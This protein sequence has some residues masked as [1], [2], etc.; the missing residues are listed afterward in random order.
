MVVFEF[1]GTSTGAEAGPSISGLLQKLL[2]CALPTCDPYPFPV[3]YMPFVEPST[4][5][6]LAGDHDIALRVSNVA[7]GA[8]RD[9]RGPS[10]SVT[11]TSS[12]LEQC[13]RSANSSQILASEI[14]DMELHGCGNDDCPYKLDSVSFTLNANV[15]IESDVDGVCA[16]GAR[17]LE[18]FT[19]RYDFWSARMSPSYFS[20]F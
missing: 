8:D 14:I 19:C 17:Q 20:L 9:L 18:A 3:C 5:V 12:V 11:L 6:V 1:T 2:V 16:D 10:V 13:F 15:S 7:E 4:E